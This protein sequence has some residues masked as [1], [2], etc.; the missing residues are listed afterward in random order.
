[1]SRALNHDVTNSPPDN[2]NPAPCIG[3]YQVNSLSPSIPIDRAPGIMRTQFLSRCSPSIIITTPRRHASSTSFESYV[4][5]RV[6]IDL[7]AADSTF[8]REYKP[9]SKPE[10][11]PKPKPVEK[12]G[13]KS[14]VPRI[15]SAPARRSFK[16]H[17]LLLTVLPRAPIKLP[18]STG[19]N[20]IKA[21][22]LVAPR[23]AEGLSKSLSAT[24]VNRSDKN[25]VPLDTPR[26]SS[27]KTRLKIYNVTPADLLSYALFGDVRTV[28]QLSKEKEEALKQPPNHQKINL[29]AVLAD[30][31]IPPFE[32]EA[33]V[34]TQ[35]THDF[36][37]D[38]ERRLEEAGFGLECART[39]YK[40]F[41]SL[42][43]LTRIF[44]MLSGTHMGLK[45]F[46]DHH[47][48]RAFNNFSTSVSTIEIAQVRRLFDN[49]FLSLLSMGI[50]PSPDICAFGVYFAS[51]LMELEP[52]KQRPFSATKQYLRMAANYAYKTSPETRLALDLW[53]KPLFPQTINQRLIDSDDFETVFRVIT[54][55]NRSS[56][57]GRTEACFRSLNDRNSSFF[58]SVYTSYIPKLGFCGFSDLL[59]HE[60]ES[61]D[62]EI[63]PT[64][65]I[66]SI[67]C[68]PNRRRFR[69]QM[70]AIAFLR[71]KD[72]KR[73]LSVLSSVPE[74]HQ[75]SPNSSPF[76]P[77][78]LWDKNWIPS[79]LDTSRDTRVWLIALIYSHFLD[80]DLLLV[81]DNLDNRSAREFIHNTI[82]TLPNKPRAC[83]DA[84]KS[85]LDLEVPPKSLLSYLSLDPRKTRLVANQYH[86]E[87]ET[88]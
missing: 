40:H 86:L 62:F 32:T 6:V 65:R 22:L 74:D 31:I 83:L 19:S 87:Q 78:F 26:A 85:L 35:L 57:E 63:K 34:I 20:R 49:L 47:M 72:P 5:P 12:L 43:E 9:E 79:H 10:S 77:P 37:L 75:D 30:R 66:P 3:E 15:L 73:A 33:R 67:L 51:R 55:F 59:W 8:V 7:D 82:L 42:A 29:R 36:F 41:S 28:P 39:E 76:N 70:F 46:R 60:W 11:Q 27:H 13:I 25:R 88:R 21:H 53:F 38:P 54:G 69:A 14:P 52:H 48:K 81:V 45:F 61:T 44:S 1:M 17:R 71:A 18:R 64:C 23:V 2:F 16:S 56:E 50:L 84:L 68:G 80:S 58:G 4:L 24:N